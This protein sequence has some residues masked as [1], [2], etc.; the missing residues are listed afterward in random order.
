[1]YTIRG[2]ALS[3]EM[4]LLPAFKFLHQP[5]TYGWGFDLSA[6]L[7]RTFQS[8]TTKPQFMTEN[9]RPGQLHGLSREH[10][11]LRQLWVSLCK[12]HVS[13]KTR[14]ICCVK[15]ALRRKLAS[16][17]REVGQ[18]SWAQ[19]R[20]NL[21]TELSPPLRG[22]ASSPGPVGFAPTIFSFF[23]DLFYL[24]AMVG[25]RCCTGLSLFSVSRGSSLVVECRL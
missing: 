13:K 4:S 8:I 15:K 1:M 23:L 6:V 17:R 10:N 7:S 9:Q 3:Q 18:R 12:S 14:L 16:M 22:P 25:L 2:F 24:L 21:P 19:T 5:Q 20:L 11:F